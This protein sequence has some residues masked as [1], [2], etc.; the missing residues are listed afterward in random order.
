MGAEFL[1]EMALV[2]EAHV[3]VEVWQITVLVASRTQ[4][5]HAAV[6]SAVTPQFDVITYFLHHKSFSD[7]LR[8]Q[9]F[10]L[11]LNIVA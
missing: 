3:I 7:V 2:K 10:T 5:F 8:E 11:A 4:D 1:A 9:D 6:H